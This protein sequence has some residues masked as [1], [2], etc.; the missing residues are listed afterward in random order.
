MDRFFLNLRVGSAIHRFNYAVDLSG[1]LFHRHSHHNLTPE[2]IGEEIKLEDL[3]L[4]VERQC[5]QRLPKTRA[6]LFSIR[7]YVTPIIEVTKDRDVA[8]AFRTNTGSFS[9][10]VA[11][12]KN[13]SLWDPILQKHFGEILDESADS[14]F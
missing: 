8:R 6:F 5:L 3:H 2:T 4:R 12:Y 11:R 13:R 9:E 14:T 1:Q 10:D 7:T